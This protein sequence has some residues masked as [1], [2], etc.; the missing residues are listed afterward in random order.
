[1]QK[2]L[3][4]PC[5]VAVLLTVFSNPARAQTAAEAEAARETYIPTLLL[6]PAPALETLGLRAAYVSE[7][8][9]PGNGRYTCGGLDRHQ[10]EK[11]VPA[12]ITAAQKIPAAA[13]RKIN[14]KYLLLCSEAKAGSRVIGGIPVAPLRLLMLSVGKT[15]AA[16]SGFAHT[17]LHELY[18]LIEMQD[19]SFTDVEWNNAFSGY[20]HFYGTAAGDTAAGSGGKGFVNGYGKSFPHEERAEIFALH[21][22]SPERLQDAIARVRDDVLQQKLDFVIRKSRK[23]L[24]PDVF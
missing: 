23:M 22:L 11:T 9:T 24:G 18:H 12:I 20:D 2:Y 15:P 17:L 4:L 21:A 16:T 3:L 5:L 13:W 19:N 1:M 7:A 14:L 6:Y 8:V 10:L